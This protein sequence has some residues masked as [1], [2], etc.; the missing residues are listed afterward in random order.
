M[1]PQGKFEIHRLL[2]VKGLT[3]ISVHLACLFRLHRT[4]IRAVNRL[5]AWRLSQVEGRSWQEGN[6]E[7]GRGRESLQPNPQLR[8]RPQSRYRMPH[9]APPRPS[10]S[11]PL[12]LPSPPTLGESTRRLPIAEPDSDV[13]L[14]FP[15]VIA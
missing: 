3:C 9:S 11:F 4:N 2:G 12:L 13:S 7:E 10:S 5:S 6:R 14:L 8:F 1:R 15:L